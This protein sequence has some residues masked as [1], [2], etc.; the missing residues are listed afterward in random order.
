VFAFCTVKVTGS[1]AVFTLLACASEGMA[2]TAAQQ[3]T[4]R[5]RARLIDLGA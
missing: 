4:A 3:T 5:R 1:D 2:A